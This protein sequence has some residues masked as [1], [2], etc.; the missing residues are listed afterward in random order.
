MSQKEIKELSETNSLY[1][2][3]DSRQTAQNE[4][5]FPQAKWESAE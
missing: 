4:R 3:F 2:Q 1:P 5:T